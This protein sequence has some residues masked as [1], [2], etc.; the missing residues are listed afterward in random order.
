MCAE[1]VRQRAAQ[2]FL[3]SLHLRLDR[4]ARTASDLGAL[5]PA[6]A[7]GHIYWERVSI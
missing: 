4:N 5:A 3:Q 2:A 6:V 1:F 7:Q